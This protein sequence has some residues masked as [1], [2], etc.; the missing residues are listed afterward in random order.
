MMDIN[1][2]RSIVTLL[3]FVSFIGICWF[4]WSKTSQAN[5]D[6]AARSVLQD[7]LPTGV[8]TPMRA[9]AAVADRNSQGEPS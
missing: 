7:D 8:V 2:A 1:I 5:Y 9:D 4:A 6:A 3:S